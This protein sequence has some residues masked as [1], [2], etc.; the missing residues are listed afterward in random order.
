MGSPV[1]WW[2]V[3][4]CVPGVVDTINMAIDIPRC[5]G[6][7]RGMTALEIILLATVV[8]LIL[9][10]VS[11]QSALAAHQRHLAALDTSIAAHS[12]NL[13]AQAQL[14]QLRKD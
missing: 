6:I 12:R 4:S 11:Q 10:N 5:S 9:Q 8:A 7:I 3:S 14:I 2:S 1:L 13:A